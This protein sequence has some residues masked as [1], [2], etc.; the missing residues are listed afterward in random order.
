MRLALPDDHCSCLGQQLGFVQLKMASVIFRYAKWISVAHLSHSSWGRLLIVYSVLASLID[1]VWCSWKFSFQ[2]QYSSSLALWMSCQSSASTFWL[3]LMGWGLRRKILSMLGYCREARGWD[4]HHGFES[5]RA[6]FLTT[7]Q[8]SLWASSHGIH[9]PWQPRTFRLE[10]SCERKKWTQLE[11]CSGQSQLQTRLCWRLHHSSTVRWS[12]MPS[13]LTTTWIGRICGPWTQLIAVQHRPDRERAPTGIRAL[14]VHRP[15]LQA[16][17]SCLREVLEYL[18]LAAQIRRAQLTIG[19]CKMQRSK[20]RGVRS[21][22]RG[23]SSLDLGSLETSRH[24][25]NFSL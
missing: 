12:S 6:P 5:R 10:L 2:I 13:N 4:L 21:L 24:W 17:N 7:S 15:S 11:S 22:G 19:T 25:W 16:Q 23:G 14:P 20:L 8:C 3:C 18:T 1:R 9:W